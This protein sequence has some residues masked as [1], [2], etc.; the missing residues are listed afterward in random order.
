MVLSEGVFNSI[1]ERDSFD[2]FDTAVAPCNSIAEIFDDQYYKAYENIR[3]FED[4]E[5][6]GPIHIRN[7]AGK[8][9]R[10]TGATRHAW[11]ELN[12]SNRAILIKRLGL[13]EAEL[14]SRG[15]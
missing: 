8:L 14:K 12:S 9:S 11:L 2:E 10:T 15:T 6:G 7:V 5:L 3:S 1:L 4:E 13:D